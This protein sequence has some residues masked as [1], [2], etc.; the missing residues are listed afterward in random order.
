MAFGL[1][2]N[3]QALQE[4]RETARAR[5]PRHFQ[6]LEQVEVLARLGGCFVREER[7]DSLLADAPDLLARPIVTYEGDDLHGAVFRVLVPR[8]SCR[9]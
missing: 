3:S 6:E 8:R 7:L 9:Q 4:P 1:P 2:V 5:V